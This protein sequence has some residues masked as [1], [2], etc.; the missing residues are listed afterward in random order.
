MR[1]KVIGSLMVIMII[2]T[3]IVSIL[4]TVSFSSQQVSISLFPNPKVDIVLAKSKTTTDVTNFE[5]DILNQ[6]QSLGVNTSNVQVTSVESEEIDMQ[7][8]FKWQQ[9]LDL[10]IGDIDITNDGQDVEMVGNRTLAGKNAIWIIP[11][12]TED[13]VYNIWKLWGNLGIYL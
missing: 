8:S 4:T 6:L 12:D 11:T 3:L 13:V 7:N 5:T 2:L 1:R 10:S 9:D